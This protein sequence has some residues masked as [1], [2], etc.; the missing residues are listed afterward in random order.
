M[1]NKGVGINPWG[2]KLRIADGACAGSGEN[3][4]VSIRQRVLE[5]TRIGLTGIQRGVG[6]KLGCS[7]EDGCVHT[8]CL[9][10]SHPSDIEQR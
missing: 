6:K 9:L 8:C 1:E 10:H 7:L 5:L 2:F 4:E 3:T